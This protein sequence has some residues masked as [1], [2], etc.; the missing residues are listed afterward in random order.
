MNNIDTQNNERLLPAPPERDLPGGRHHVLREFL[1]TEFHT[2]S[3]PE[4][5]PTSRPRLRRFAFSGAFAVVAALAIGF[6]L[7]LFGP[8]GS[9]PAYAITSSGDSVKVTINASGKG[10]DIADFER[11]MG[12]A[13]MPTRVVPVDTCGFS[14]A[15]IASWAKSRPNESAG[16]DSNAPALKVR[17]EAGGSLEFQ[18]MRD[19]LASGKTLV[20]FF[21]S[22]GKDFHLVA[23]IVQG[24]PKN[25]QPCDALS[26]N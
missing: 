15:D 21:N 19:R 10:F 13:G 16:T 7:A 23:G 20:L 6:G 8:D 12:A 14:Y 22:P 1:M 2:S 17:M 11:D 25:W 26:A 18:V 4:V 24:L 9:A 5:A 3:H